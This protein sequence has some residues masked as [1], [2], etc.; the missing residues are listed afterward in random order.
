M[1][2]SLANENSL[3]IVKFSPVVKKMGR[4]FYLLERTNSLE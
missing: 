1:G 2:I 4:L 3:F